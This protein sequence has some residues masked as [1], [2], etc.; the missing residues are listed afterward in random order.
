MSKKPATTTLELLSDIRDEGEIT[1]RRWWGF[2][3]RRR[4]LAGA[5]RAG[6]VSMLL[7]PGIAVTFR[8]TPLGLDKLAQ[9]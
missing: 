9:R 5:I 7:G 6:W 8:V 3:G 2:D 1:N 4:N